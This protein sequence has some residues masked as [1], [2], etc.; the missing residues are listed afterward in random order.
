MLL[1]VRLSILACLLGFYIIFVPQLSVESTQQMMVT[2]PVI[3]TDG[4]FSSGWSDVI[5]VVDNTVAPGIGPGTASG[6]V[7][8]QSSGGNPGMFRQSTHNATANDWLI[9]GGL[10]TNAI[11]DP[12]ASGEI[13]AIDFSIDLLEDPNVPGESGWQFILSQGDVVYYSLPLLVFS[14]SQWQSFK[15]FSLTASDF[16]TSPNAGLPGGTPNNQHPNFTTSGSPITFGYALGNFVVGGP[17]LT[18]HHG[19][20]NWSVVVNPSH[21]YLPIVQR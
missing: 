2:T 15:L 19:I 12:S 7:S 16:D 9:T 21:L 4:D 20:D 17:T 1:S 13:F 6:S 11:Y 8:L 3:Y 18:L 5:I 10:N 14:N